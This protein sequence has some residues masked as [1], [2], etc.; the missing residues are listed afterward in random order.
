MPTIIHVLLKIEG[1]TQWSNANTLER[2]TSQCRILNNRDLRELELDSRSAIVLRTT[3]GEVQSGV[4][5]HFAIFVRLGRGSAVTDAL[6]E[7]VSK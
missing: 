3:S 1:V 4:S 7:A 6:L 2:R 5:D